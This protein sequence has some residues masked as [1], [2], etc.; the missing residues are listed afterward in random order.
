M[1]LENENLEVDEWISSYTVQDK[2]FDIIYINK[3]GKLVLLNQKDVLDAL[4]HHKDK[5]RFVPDAID[6]GEDAANQ[7]LVSTLKAWLWR[8]RHNKKLIW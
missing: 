5:D 6:K 3:Q 8:I 1:T 7:E 4:T 2:V